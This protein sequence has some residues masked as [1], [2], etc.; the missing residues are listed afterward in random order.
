MVESKATE[1]W[2]SFNEIPD[3]SIGKLCD[4][5]GMQQYFDN[6]FWMMHSFNIPQDEKGIK[7]MNAVK[8]YFNNQEEI[9][10]DHLGEYVVIKGT[11]VITYFKD[12]MDAVEFVNK[13]ENETYIVK[14]CNPPGTMILHYNFGAMFA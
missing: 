7:V 13:D 10:K 6:K 14:K 2:G 3:E 12:Q 1:E 5:K 8:Y 11:T 9:V 4:T